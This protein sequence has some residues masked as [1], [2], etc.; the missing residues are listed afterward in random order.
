MKRRPQ[1]VVIGDSAAPARESRLAERLGARLAEL[2]F[3]LITGGRGGIMA[4]ASRGATRAGGVTV[5]IV[6]TTAHCDANPWCQI[7]LPTGLGHARNALT[8]LAG[9]VV[10]A[11]GGGA[12]T[13]SEIAFAWL[14]GRPIFLLAGTGG[15]SDALAEGPV[16]ARRSSTV[17]RC[18]DLD[19]L[20]A[21]L[22]RLRLPADCQPLRG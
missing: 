9:D 3:T 4:A 18:T 8:A 15:W 6:A 16:D 1:A 13:L 7:V 10:I 11:V 2:G 14:H 21:A 17:T 19:A 20:E 22:R 12:G 5:G